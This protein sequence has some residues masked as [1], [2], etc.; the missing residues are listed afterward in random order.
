[1]T[2]TKTKTRPHDKSK[3]H[4]SSSWSKG[5][6][7]HHIINLTKYKTPAEQ[8]SMEECVQTPPARGALRGQSSQAEEANKA[9]STNQSRIAVVEIESNIVLL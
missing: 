2:T 1:M 8:R 4:K 9:T 5:R 3:Q 6:L 7:K